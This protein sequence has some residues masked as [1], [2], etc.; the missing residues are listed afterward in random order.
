MAEQALDPPHRKLGHVGVLERLKI[1]VEESYQKMSVAYDKRDI[2]TLR[3]LV[4]DV[5]DA[6]EPAVMVR[7]GLRLTAG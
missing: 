3:R 7:L 2:A 5:I 4:V 6:L 1:V